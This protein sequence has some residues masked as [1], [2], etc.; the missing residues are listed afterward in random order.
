[1]RTSCP[2]RSL[3]HSLE[4]ASGA[5]ELAKPDGEAHPHVGLPVQGLDVDGALRLGARLPE[6]ARQAQ[7]LR[8]GDMGVGTVRTQGHR[9]L[10]VRPGLG[11]LVPLEPAQ[12][13]AHRVGLA[14]LRA[15]RHRAVRG[16]E[17][18]LLSARS[19]STSWRDSAS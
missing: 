6:V 9:L 8:Q 17:S 3:E 16:F 10:D 13:G 7:Q 14:V 19:A 18:P 4:G 11:P 1:M 12:E 15:C 2:A 5:V